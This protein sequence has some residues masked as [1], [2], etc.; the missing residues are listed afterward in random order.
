[1]RS[2]L[3][4]DSPPSTKYQFP[5][6]YLLLLTQAALLVGVNRSV[7]R[8]ASPQTVEVPFFSVCGDVSLL[9]KKTDSSVSWSRLNRMKL[10]YFGFVLCVCV[11]PPIKKKKKKNLNLEF[12]SLADWS[13]Q[14]SSSSLSL[15]NGLQILQFNL[16]RTHLLHVCYTRCALK[17]HTL[18]S[19]H[20]IGCKLEMSAFRYT[21]INTPSVTNYLLVVYVPVAL[22]TRILLE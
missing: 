13:F 14:I 16:D 5:D 19:T 21:S 22:Q 6:C 18:A 15:S 1:M 12:L 4:S 11:T 9:R 3:R 17:L 2:A 10:N 7:Y 8:A 20:Q